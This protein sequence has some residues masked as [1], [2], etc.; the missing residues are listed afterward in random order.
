MESQEWGS[1]NKGPMF[2]GTNIVF[3]RVRM[4]TYIKSLRAYLW[5]VVEE[6]YQNPPININK[7]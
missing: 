3:W 5:D 7:H 1:T 2:N 4:N 6:E